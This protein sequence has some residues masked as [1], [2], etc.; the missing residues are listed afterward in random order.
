MVIEERITAVIV[1]VVVPLMF[2]IDAV[3]V[4]EPDV[5]ALASPILLMVAIPVF[6]ELHVTD[7]VISFVVLSV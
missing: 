1:R 5:T 2:P 7:E 6:E 3:M 4:V